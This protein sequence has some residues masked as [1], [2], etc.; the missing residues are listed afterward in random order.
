M[1]FN[2]NVEILFLGGSSRE[3]GLS[4]VLKP[5][6]EETDEKISRMTWTAANRGKISTRHRKFEYRE[7]DDRVEIDRGNPPLKSRSRSCVTSLHVRSERRT[8]APR[9]LHMWI[10]RN[11]KKL[12]VDSPASW[13]SREVE[14]N[15]LPRADREIAIKFVTMEEREINIGDRPSVRPLRAGRI[16]RSDEIS[17]GSI[18]PMLF[19]SRIPRR[20]ALPA[21]KQRCSASA[22]SLDFYYDKISRQ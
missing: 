11:E 16:T 1:N 4:G 19:R 2:E 7:T 22:S 21:R 8:R 13:K 20:I 6:E 9:A 3:R 17:S 10:R 18:A 15:A 12:N 5:D 14:T